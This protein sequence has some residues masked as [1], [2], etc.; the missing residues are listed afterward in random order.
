MQVGI[1]EGGTPI[2]DETINEIIACAENDDYSEFEDVSDCVYGHIAPLS[3]EKVTISFTLPTSAA[4][5]L[6]SLAKKQSCT[7]S[8]VL[9]SFVFDGL[10]RTSV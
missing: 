7:R 10:L 1:D 9:R 4:D 6:N 2:T 5:E 3:Q 8:D